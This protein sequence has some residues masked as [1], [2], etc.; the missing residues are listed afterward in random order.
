MAGLWVL[1]DFMARS[2]S[3]STLCILTTDKTWS[4]GL[5]VLLPPFPAYCHSFPHQDRLHLKPVN[6]NKHFLCKSFFSGQLVTE[7]RKVT[8]TDR[9]NKEG[10]EKSCYLDVTTSSCMI[11][12]K[13]LSP[14]YLGFLVSDKN[15]HDHKISS[16]L[17]AM[18]I[19]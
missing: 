6:R 10:T 15:N 16:S 14:L 1:V 17:I 18:S 5:Y 8:S 2:Q 19:K 4:A 13:L 12:G 3:L 11:L 7:V 9:V